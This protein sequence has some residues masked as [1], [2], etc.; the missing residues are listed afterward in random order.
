[1]ATGNANTHFVSVPGVRL[2]AVAAGIRA[3]G[4]ND[5]VLMEFAAGSTSAGVFTR[6]L[7]AAAPV[8]VGRRH[9][10]S[11]SPRY[12]LIN[13]GNAN[14]GVGDAG[15]A[16][17]LHS[18][19]SLARVTGVRPEEIIPFSTGVIGERLPVDKIE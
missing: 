4:R 3:D 13:S 1:M 17:A 19:E 15:I 8:Q 11:M 18:C 12:F 5:L 2:G 14:A 10:E 6:N 7:F 9:L 16:D